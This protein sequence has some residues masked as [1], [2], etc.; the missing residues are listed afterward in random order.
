MGPAESLKSIKPTSAAQLAPLSNVP[1]AAVPSATPMAAARSGTLDQ[2]K[3]HKVA[4]Q[5]E[6]MFMTEMVHQMHPKPQSNGM[7]RAG[8]G[9]NAMQPF[10]DQALGGA[11]AAR[12]GAGLTPAI[13][14]ALNAAA[15]RN[16]K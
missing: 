11:I 15:A 2:A 1:L 13:E 12:G 6:A 5:F 9:E 8:I 3:L 16:G 14:R 10:M 4:T 7:F